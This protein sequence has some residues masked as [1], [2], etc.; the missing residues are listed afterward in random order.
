MSQA[1]LEG[2]SMGLLLSAMI[3]P[4]F[5]TLIQSSLEHGFRYAAMVA[6]GIVC[7][8]T[9][10]VLLTFFGIKFLANTGSFEQVLGY[11]GGAILIGFGISYLVKKQGLAPDPALVVA[12]KVKKRS[13]YLKGFSINGINPFVMLFW[14]SIASLVQLKTSFNTVDVWLYYVGILLTVFTIDLV[15]A[16]IAKK[17][18]KFVTPKFMFW[19]NKGVGVV[20]IGFG[21]RLIWFAMG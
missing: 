12:P 11:V 17:L 9:L 1:L 5:F 3:G 2:I 7:S 8:D 21:L 18:S 16:Y 15:K 13:A 19:L 10:Y 20:M 4:V 14:I 6:L